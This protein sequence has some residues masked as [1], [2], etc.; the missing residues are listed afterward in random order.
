MKQNTKRSMI[1]VFGPSLLVVVASSELP[2]KQ[3]NAGLKETVLPAGVKAIWD[4]GKAYRV[5][6]ATRE[7]VC[8]NGLWRWQPAGHDSESVPADRWGFFKVPGF[9]PGNSNHLQEDCQTVHAHP[10][11]K[12]QNLPEITGAWYQREITVPGQWSGRR[13]TLAAEVVNS[14]AVVYV[15][16]KKAGAIRFPAGEV[17]LTSLCRPGGKHV[18]SVLVLALPLKSVMLTYTDTN[19]A[20]LQRGSAERRGLCGDIYLAST[21]AKARITDLK[22]ETSIRRGEITLSAAHRSFRSKGR[23][24]QTANQ[25]KG[26]LSSRY[27]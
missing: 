6:T 23:D 19:S 15:D 5:K 9:W 14:F 20:K 4:L 24:G 16:G 10:G 21:P 22:I 26:T 11:W 17:E 3:V 25:S 27:R 1:L 12:N 13:I 7:R 18:L 2:A 8:L